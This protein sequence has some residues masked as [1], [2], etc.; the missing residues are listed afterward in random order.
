MLRGCTTE[1]FCEGGGVSVYLKVKTCIGRCMS[2][3]LFYIYIYL[4]TWSCTLSFVETCAFIFPCDVGNQNKSICKK[5]PCSHWTGFKEGV[6]RGW[7][8]QKSRGFAWD[9]ISYRAER[10]CV[11]NFMTRMNYIPFFTLL[12]SVKNHLIWYGRAEWQM[13]GLTWFLGSK[14]W[15]IFGSEW[16]CSWKCQFDVNIQQII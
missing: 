11:I 12:M 16:A 3:S 6:R 1:V 4:N 9:R 7:W 8:L 2:Q 15:K 5:P 10:R 14:V 13:N